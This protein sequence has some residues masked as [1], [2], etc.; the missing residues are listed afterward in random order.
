M[1]PMTMHPAFGYK[2]IT[3]GNKRTYSFW[4]KT[5]TAGR[6]IMYSGLAQVREALLLHWT[7]PVN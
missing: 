4:L 6:G 7:D 1:V 5:S 2:G 3:G